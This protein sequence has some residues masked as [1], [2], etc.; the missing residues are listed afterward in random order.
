MKLALNQLGLVL[1]W[2][3]AATPSQAQSAPKVESAT[4]AILQALQS[5]DL[6]MLGEPHGNK[7]EYDWLRS[8]VGTPEFADCVDEIVM[9]FGNSLYQPIVDRYVRGEG[10]PI[11]TFKVPG[12]T[13]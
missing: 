7:Q 5:H 13:R 9:E 11:T 1:L 2:T 3:V 8:L 4:P 10:I 6:V 12:A